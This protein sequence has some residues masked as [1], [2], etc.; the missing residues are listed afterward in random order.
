MR[1]FGR[2]GWFAAVGLGIGLLGGGR[3]V[4]SQEGAGAVLP[5]VMGERAGPTVTA[6]ATG[7]AT[8]TGTPTAT[9]TATMTPTATGTATPTRTPTMTA[10]PS[11]TATATA[12]PTRTPTGTAT[13]TRD[14]G[15]C[16]PSYPDHCIPPPPPDLNC[17]DVPWRNFTV[18]PPDPHNFDGNHNGIGCESD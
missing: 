13:P 3:W 12:T 16:H 10:T 7:T 17:D 6:T 5:V 14:P 15:Q 2:V 18:L 11:R 4:V 9:G 8:D 1:G